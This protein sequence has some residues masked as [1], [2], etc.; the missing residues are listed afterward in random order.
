MVSW[1]H[2]TRPRPASPKPN[3]S[4]RTQSHPKP[5]IYGAGMPGELQGLR[6]MS[7]WLHLDFDF[8]FGRI[9][10]IFCFVYLSSFQ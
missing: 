1:C 6:H 9:E 2:G 8:H 10:M 5:T 4:A 3:P 7:T